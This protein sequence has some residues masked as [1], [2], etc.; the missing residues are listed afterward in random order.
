MLGRLVT[1]TT[2]DGVRLDGFLALP[3]EF[4]NTVWLVSHGVNSNFYGSTLLMDLAG[5]FLDAGTAVLL[6]N[7]RGHDVAAFNAG[8][9]PMRL[10]SQF[11]TVS[12]C[13]LDFDA[14]IEFL[15]SE[16]FT[17]IGC[18]GHSLGAVKV[19]YWLA[20]LQDVRVYAGIAL[21]P[22]RLSKGLLLDDPKRGAVFAEHLRQAKQLCDE[23]KP[24][25]V[26]KVR[27]PLP[28]W[29]C[30]ATYLDKYGNDLKYDYVHHSA[31]IPIPVLWLFGE[32]EIRDGSSNFRDADRILSRRLAELNSLGLCLDHRLG[33]IPSA[34]HSYRNQRHELGEQI[35]AWIES[36][37]NS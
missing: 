2:A 21:S 1:T 26:M 12:N 16:G 10:G 11:E 17:R 36:Q 29:I 25:E 20:H 24:E 18:A 22:P 34:D 13:T 33:V 5:L 14:W 8:D 19:I 37:R 31:A 3:K 27:F 23:G 15:A 28:T 35:A 30:A 6:A 32:L 9:V 4:S 7:N